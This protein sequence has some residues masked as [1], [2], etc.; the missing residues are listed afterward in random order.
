MH[1]HV[2]LHEYATAW[3]HTVHVLTGQN[4]ICLEVVLLVSLQLGRQMQHPKQRHHHP[5]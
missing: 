4:L 1:G 5:S 2:E 3:M